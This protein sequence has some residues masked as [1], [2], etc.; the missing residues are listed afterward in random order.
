[1]I[2]WQAEGVP[3]LNW[4]RESR[5][6]FIN[7][8]WRTEGTS[9]IT[10]PPLIAQTLW[11]L[12]EID[13]DGDLLADIYPVVRTHLACLA[14]ERTFA[15]DHLLYLINP[16]ESG[17]DNSPRFD[18]SLHLPA[19]H[20]ADENLDKRME[21]M[22]QNALCDFAAKTCMSNFFGVAD[23]SFNVLY[24]EELRAMARISEVLG[25]SEAA[26]EYMNESTLVQRDIVEKM[27]QDKLFLSYDH[28]KKQPVHVLTWNIF[29]PLY[30][31]LLT[32]EEARTL[33]DTYLWNNTIF[34]SEFGIV[35]TAKTEAAYDPQTGFWRGP[36]WAAPHWFI[37]QGLKRYGFF[38]E[39]SEIKE[40]TKRLIL[41]G[42]FREHYHPET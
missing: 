8:L 12:Y 20:S 29:M 27:R 7:S 24:V 25:K 4:G 23:V 32:P 21:L 41:T 18:T 14:S 26:R 39:A 36:I 19:T 2:F 9:S 35:T 6:E 15:G 17:E 42:G 22:N 3:K 16:D 31:G 34:K 1:M 33:V 28:L 37:Y 38:K 40:M 5:G 10:Q 13:G 30:G 11:R